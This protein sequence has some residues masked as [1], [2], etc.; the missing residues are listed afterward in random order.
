VAR[1][2]EG[3]HLCACSSRAGGELGLDV[4]LLLYLSMSMS[5]L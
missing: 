5:I 4:G 3:R 2:R 1:E